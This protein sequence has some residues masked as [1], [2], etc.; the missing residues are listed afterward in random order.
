MTWFSTIL[1][2]LRQEPEVWAAYFL[3]QK[4][5]ERASG[6][7]AKPRYSGLP[8]RLAA[9][10]LE[11]LRA[12]RFQ[13]PVGVTRRVDVLVLALTRNQANSLIATVHHLQTK[14]ISVHCVTGQDAASAERVFGDDVCQRITLSLFDSIKVALLTLL[15]APVIWRQLA[16]KDR[17]LRKLHFDAFLKCHIYLVYFEKALTSI[18]PSLILM[19]NDHNSEQRCLLSLARVKG[20]R[21]VYLQH[22][23]VS[24]LFPALMFDYSLLDGQVAIDNYIQCN[25]NKPKSATVPNRRHIFLTGQKRSVQPPCSSRGAIVGFAIKALDDERDV[26]QVVRA[27]TDAG[28]DLRLRWHP[29]TD[30]AKAN[31]I[32]QAC[33]E[34]PSVGLSDPHIETVGDFLAQTSVLVA[35][36]S[37]IHLEAAVAGVLPVYFEMLPVSTRDYYGYVKNGVSAEARDLVELRDLIDDV[38][39]GRRTLNPHAVKA[40]SA[41][42][43]TEWEGR[44]GELAARIIKSLLEGANPAQCWGYAGVV[45]SGENQQVET[46]KSDYAPNRSS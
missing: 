23:S 15:R 44:E 11:L 28:Y 22:A 7:P 20:I 10:V 19:S 25:S 45:K 13:S 29:G 3:G 41:T 26:M 5:N 6:I 33:L 43:N 36:N 17:R 21:T 30:L 14:G 37:S 35:A 27:I 16:L 2:A 32:R 31:E 1:R 18:N 12:T 40:Y 46:V 34:I 9:Y 38:L 24:R 42:F 4:F 8:L 39:K